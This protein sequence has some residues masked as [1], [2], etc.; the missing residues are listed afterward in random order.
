MAE[1]QPKVLNFASSMIWVS[2]FTLICS[3]ITSPHSGARMSCTL[4]FCLFAHSVR[5]VV[6]LGFRIGA[7]DA[8]AD[9][10]VRQI[11]TRA[12]SLQ[13]IRWLKRRRGACRSARDRH[14]IDAHQ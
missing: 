14:V 13:D 3:F 9:G 12:Q 5:H 11:V 8:E 2:G 7:A 4:P 10:T 6:A 1:P